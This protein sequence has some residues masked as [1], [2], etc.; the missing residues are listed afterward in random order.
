[1]M[2]LPKSP[3]PPV[4]K[5]IGNSYWWRF[6]AVTASLERKERGIARLLV[7]ETGWP[8]LLAGEMGLP[9]LFVW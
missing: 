9:G 4:T 1:M 3:V 6:C 5:F 7:G 8:G 2:W